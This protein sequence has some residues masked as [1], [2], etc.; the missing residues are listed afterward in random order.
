MALEQVV[1]LGHQLLEAREAIGGI[2]AI[3]EKGKLEPA[4][5]VVVDRLE[6]LLRISGVDEHRQVQARACVPD[7]IELGIVDPQPC[8]IDLPDI[9]A[10]LFRDL[11]DTDGARPHVGFELANGPVGPSG[12]NVAKIDPGEH[13]NAIFLR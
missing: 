5:V 11:A 10:E 4:L 3:G 9:Q 2:T 8:P 12:S 1:A 6:E 13:T 7:G